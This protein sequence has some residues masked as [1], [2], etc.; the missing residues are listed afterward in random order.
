MTRD[1]W[2]SDDEAPLG[3]LLDGRVDDLDDRG[4]RIRDDTFLV[5]FQAGARPAAFVCPE[6]ARG[7]WELDWVTAEGAELSGLTLRLTADSVCVLREERGGEQ[8]GPDAYAV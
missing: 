5:V 2:Q 1:D 8:P 3:L 7:H 6:P 4:R